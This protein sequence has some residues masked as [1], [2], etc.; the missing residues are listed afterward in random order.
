MSGIRAKNTKPELQIR[1]LLH[2]LGFRY[3]LHTANLAGKPDI[4]LP[5]YRTVVF[6]QGCFWHGHENCQVFRLPKTRTGFWR[7]KIEGNKT[8]DAMTRRKLESGNWKII[9]VWECA[10]KGKSKLDHPSL[11]NLLV[12]S[13]KQGEQGF[14]DIRGEVIQPLL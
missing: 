4:V 12:S 3:R 7:T 2:A 10:I 9:Y 13:I 1:K 11:A 8:R 6:V 5:K 14:F